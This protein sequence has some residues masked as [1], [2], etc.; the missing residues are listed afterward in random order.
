[1]LGK[2]KTKE[3]KKE[4]L[5]YNCIICSEHIIDGTEASIRCNKYGDWCHQLFVDMDT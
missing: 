3:K 2:R 4:K 1:M 5:I